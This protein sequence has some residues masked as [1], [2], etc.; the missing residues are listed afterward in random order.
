M[1][2]SPTQA[3][4][5]ILAQNYLPKALALAESL[6]RQHGATLKVMLIDVEEPAGLPEIP[7]VELIST[8]DPPVGWRLRPGGV[9]HVDQG[10]AAPAAP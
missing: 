9:R 4:C 1:A 6:K 3:F 8:G 10:C 7:G 2:Q 5:T